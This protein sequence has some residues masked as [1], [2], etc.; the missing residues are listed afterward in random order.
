MTNITITDRDDGFGAQFQH[1][2]YG[3]IYAEMNH[4]TY[5]HK[6][7]T[8][9]AHN[10]EDDPHFVNEI[11]EFMNIKN[12]YKT[13]REIS[14]VE[15]VD[16]WTLYNFITNYENVDPR[17]E[18]FNFY[19]SQTNVLEK[20][21]SIFWENKINPFCNT[22]AT[23]VAVH[24]R[25]PNRE[26]NRIEGSNTPDE[27]YLHIIN[28]VRHTETIAHPDKKVFFH[29]YS[30]KSIDVTKYNAEDMILHIDEDIKSTFTGFVGADIFIGSNSSFSYCAGLLSE[31][32]VYF[33]R[34]NSTLSPPKH[35][36]IF[37]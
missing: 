24:I 33:I 26:D 36:W 6:P 31:G 2:I 3:I 32:K 35:D 13:T 29:I 22:S 34:S 16:F 23:N 21:K 9:M 15:V 17:K 4:K 27:S 19:L 8:R 20:I 14:N 37:M 25:R 30:Q 5:I 10:Y 7:I 28:H 11:E 1:I 12:H 18:K